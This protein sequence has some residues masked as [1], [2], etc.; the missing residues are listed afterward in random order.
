M[1]ST[2]EEGSMQ[3]AALLGSCRAPAEGRASEAQRRVGTEAAGD[4][5]MAPVERQRGSLKL[6]AHE[7]E[8]AQSAGRRTQ[9][10][11]QAQGKEG[12]MM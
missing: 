11:A 7:E 1:G 12:L 6:R 9:A 8:G 10:A 4:R 5:G 3:G 2:L